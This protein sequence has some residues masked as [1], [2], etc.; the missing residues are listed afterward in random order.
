MLSNCGAAEDSWE[1]LRQQRDQTN[2]KRKGNQPWIF[3]G[4]TDAETPILWPPDAKTWISGKDPDTGKDWGKEK[5]GE[6]EGEIIGWHHQ[7][8]RQEFEQTLRQIVK[9]REAWHAEVCG[10]RE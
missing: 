3:I 2:V 8:N 9:E 6:T 4:R 1:S 7:H 5:N 10:S